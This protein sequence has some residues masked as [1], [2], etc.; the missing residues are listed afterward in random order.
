MAEKWLDWSNL[1]SVAHQLHE[2]IDADIKRDT[3]KLES[4]EDFAAS[5][6]TSPR[7]LKAFADQR[8]AFLLKHPALAK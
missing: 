6:E 1:G 3:K 2:L 8:R 7:S 4:Y 5:L